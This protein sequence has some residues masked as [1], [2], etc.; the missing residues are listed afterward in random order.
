MKTYCEAKL[1][2]VVKKEGKDKETNKEFV[3]Y[4][5]TFLSS[6]GVIMFT[7]S[8]D[9]TSSIDKD[10]S[11]AI[12]VVGLEKQKQTKLIDVKPIDIE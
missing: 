7:S 11:V 5:N 6:D 10:C 8:K 3:W 1:L 2:S 9:Y 4:E 12:D